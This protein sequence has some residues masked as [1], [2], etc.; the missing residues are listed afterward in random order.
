VADET[1]VTTGKDA[2]PTLGKLS[3][4]RLKAALE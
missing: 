4:F 1:P 2:C 3:W